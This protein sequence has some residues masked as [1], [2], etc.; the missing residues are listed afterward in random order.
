MTGLNFNTTSSAFDLHL[1]YNTKLHRIKEFLE[2]QPQNIIPFSKMVEARDRLLLRIEQYLNKIPHDKI[3]YEP[4]EI[5]AARHAPLPIHHYIGDKYPIYVMTSSV[6]GKNTE[7]ACLEWA[8][9][10]WKDGE[11]IEAPMANEP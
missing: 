10:L 8:C 7:A 11:K 3:E 5:V 2:S 9:Y 1:Y 6:F 4:L